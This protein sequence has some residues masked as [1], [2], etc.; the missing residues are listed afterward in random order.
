MAVIQRI[1]MRA[2]AERWQRWRL[3]TE[4][5]AEKAMQAKLLHL[6]AMHGRDRMIGFMKRMLNSKV[7]RQFEFG[8]IAVLLIFRESVSTLQNVFVGQ[9]SRARHTI[10]ARISWRRNCAAVRIQTVLGR[11]PPQKKKLVELQAPL[12]S[13]AAPFIQRHWRGYLGRKAAIA[14]RRAI[15]RVFQRRWAAFYIQ[16]QWRGSK[17]REFVENLKMHMPVRQ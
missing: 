11:G 8:A 7:Q 16:G 13:L 5:E 12:Q 2:V 17:G 6:Q 14:Q 4:A 15:V 3:H 10:A 1:R 9:A